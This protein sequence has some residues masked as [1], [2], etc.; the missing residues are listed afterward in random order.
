MKKL[1]AIFFCAWL[2]A[3]QA[4]DGLTGRQSQGSAQI[5]LTILPLIVLHKLTKDEK[6]A[7]NEKEDADAEIKSNIKFKIITVQNQKKQKVSI[8]VPE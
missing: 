1:L 7:S 4:A 3:A 5:T 2:P 8:F 6:K